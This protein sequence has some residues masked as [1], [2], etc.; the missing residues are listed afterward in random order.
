VVM[1]AVWG[2]TSIAFTWYVFI[3]AFT[4]CGLAWLVSKLVPATVALPAEDTR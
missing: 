1:T 3:G 4:T 2:A